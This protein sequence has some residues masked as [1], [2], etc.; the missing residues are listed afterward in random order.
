MK[1]KVA[2]AGLHMWEEPP[3]SGDRGSGTIFFSGCAMKCVYC[4]NYEISYLNKGLFVSEEELLYLMQYLEGRG[5]HN[6]NL[7]NPSHYIKPLRIFLDKNKHRVNIPVLYNSGGYDEVEDLRDLEGLIDIYMP[8]MKYSDSKLAKRYSNKEDYYDKAKDAIIE[9]R[10]Q[11]KEDTIIDGIMSKGVIVRHL[12]LPGC[13]ED[14]KAVLDTL[15][16]ID[17]EMYISVMGQYFPTARAEHYPE[18]NRR[19]SPR[20][21]NSVIEYFHNIGLSNGF[22]QDLS[23]AI[24]DYVPE[25]DL[26]ELRTLIDNR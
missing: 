18:I 24:K 16:Q 5:A 6:I 9:M 4:Q 12:V 21:Y 15:Y 7:V 13:I 10:R 3:I 8:D 17:K 14:S 26:E 1:Y 2:R 22:L 25:F 20:E 19:I 23:S 11:R